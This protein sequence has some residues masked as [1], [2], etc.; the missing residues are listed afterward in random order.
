MSFISD[1]TSSLG[2]SYISSGGQNDSNPIPVRTELVYNQGRFSCE[3]TYIGKLSDILQAQKKSQIEQ[4]TLFL[5]SDVS[6]K[7]DLSKLSP[8]IRYA[9]F[10]C[11]QA[12]LFNALSQISSNTSFSTNSFARCIEKLFEQKYQSSQEISK[13]IGTLPYPVGRFVRFAV[14]CKKNSDSLF[15]AE[16]FAESLENYFPK[17]NIAVYNEKVI[18]LVDH[19][20][21]DFE[22]FDKHDAVLNSFLKSSDAYLMYSN[23]SRDITSL[24]SIIS[25]TSTTLNL[26]IKLNKD[27]GAHIFYYEDY[28]NYC[29]LDMA[30]QTY[31]AQNQNGDLLHL[32]HP[33][34]IAITRYDRRYRTNLRDILYQYLVNDRNLV[35]TAE[36]TFL[37]RNTVINKMNK[38]K[39]IIVLDLDDAKF[40][41]R[42]IFSIQ[43]LK[44]YEDILALNVRD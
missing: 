7:S 36:K 32:V 24:K 42:M 20:E 40:R 44:Y 6:E 21:R 43:F 10:S 19:E 33:A 39:Q 26:A 18:I 14:A 3:R 34:A 41:Q 12:M 5:I 1:L 27:S 29:I 38:I 30:I 28:C 2:A 9:A 37:H 35:K 23:A 8:K 13:D 15:S 11:N 22:P 16:S 31:L 25:L 4:G 17:R